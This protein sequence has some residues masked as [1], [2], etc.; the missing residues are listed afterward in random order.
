MSIHSR[1]FISMHKHYDLMETMTSR[2]L[3]DAIR[4]K[5]SDNDPE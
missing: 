5:K 4:S 1:T 2:Y 3:L